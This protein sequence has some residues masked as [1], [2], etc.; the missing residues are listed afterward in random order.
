MHHFNYKNGILHAEDVSLEDIAREVGTPAYV[1]SQATLLRH[2]EAFSKAFEGMDNLVCYA[3]K[4]N[5]NKAVMALFA[6]LGGGVVY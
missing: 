6:S 5:S 2:F 4:A 1:Y 3:V